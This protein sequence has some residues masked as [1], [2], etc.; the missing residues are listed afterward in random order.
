M[1]PEAILV[2]VQSYALAIFQAVH[3]QEALSFFLRCRSRPSLVA[4]R[5]AAGVRHAGVGKRLQIDV[6]S[7]GVGSVDRWRSDV[8]QGFEIDVRKG[9]EVCI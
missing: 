2:R 6:K 7:W 8:Y 9:M 1:L 5:A 4:P 3:A